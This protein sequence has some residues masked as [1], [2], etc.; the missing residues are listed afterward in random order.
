M[1]EGGTAAALLLEREGELAELGAVL[2]GL[3]HRRGRVVVIE[4]AAGI[5]KSRLLAE[6][7]D[8]ARAGGLEVL[9]GRGGELE[10]GYGFGI[11]RQLLEAS[12]ARASPEDRRDL[13]SGAAGLA[14]A[15][16]SAP[17]SGSATG[18]DTTQP[19]LHGPYWLV[20]NLAERSPLLLTIDDVQWVD[21]PSLRFLV[22][23]ARRLEA[24]PVALVLALRTGEASA[25]PELL[26]ALRLEADP[27]VLEPRALGPQATRALAADRLGRAVPDDLGR[28]CHDATRGNP[29]L[30]M[31]LLHELRSGPEETD[32]AAVGRMAPG[33]IAAAI[34]LRIGLLG[35]SAVVLVRAVCVLGESAEPQT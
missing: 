22:Y 5:G 20:A 10:R 26:R 18:A 32:A 3:R 8:R 6:T 14:E 25:E 15:V 9:A 35:P 34:L 1:T 33:R 28:A 16:F 31:E 12:V 2:A 30:L 13:L 27:P 21:A 11:V 23:L 17:A 7:R 29:F 19:V 4:G 24:M